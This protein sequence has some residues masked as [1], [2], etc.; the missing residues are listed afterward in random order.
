MLR[1][2]LLYICGDMTLYG[3]MCAS[4]ADPSKCSMVGYCVLSNMILPIDMIHSS[5]HDMNIMGSRQSNG[6][7]RAF[8]HFRTSTK[9]CLTTNVGWQSWMLLTLVR[10]IHEVQDVAV[11]GNNRDAEENSIIHD[12]IALCVLVS[13]QTVVPVLCAFVHS[14]VNISFDSRTHG[15]YEYMALDRNTTED[16]QLASHHIQLVKHLLFR[17]V[18]NHIKVLPWWELACI[19]LLTR[20]RKQAGISHATC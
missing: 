16:M 13:T 3:N 11:G 18:L 10:W 4:R 8:F 12:A 1:D 5:T 17:Q 20:Q 7:C 15:Y 2:S 9:V 19:I 14:T 6:F